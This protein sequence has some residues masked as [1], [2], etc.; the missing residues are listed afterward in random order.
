MYNSY[1]YDIWLKGGIDIKGST[2]FPMIDGTIKADKGTVKYLRTDFKLN[3]AGLVWVDPRQLP[4]ERKSGQ[5][6]ALQPL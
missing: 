6:S 3:Q 2:R 4:A 5:H 1:L